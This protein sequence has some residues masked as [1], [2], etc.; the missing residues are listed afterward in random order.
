MLAYD[1]GESA[2]A[3]GVA[4]AAGA[5]LS[6][7]EAISIDAQLAQIEAKAMALLGHREELAEAKHAASEAEARRAAAEAAGEAR[8]VSLQAAVAQAAEV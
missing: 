2:A 7:E 4:A 1:A 8:E 3:A 5:A 6:A